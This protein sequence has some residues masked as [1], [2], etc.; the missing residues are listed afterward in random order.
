MF[1]SHLL[2]QEG[3]SCAPLIR[4]ELRKRY[5]RFYLRLEGRGTPTPILL[6]SK[7]GVG[8]YFT[9]MITPNLEHV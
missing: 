7:M 9:Y 1:A 2:R 8:V 6:Y 5:A 3:R 4:G